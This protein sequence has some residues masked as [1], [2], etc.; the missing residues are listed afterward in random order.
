MS[1]PISGTIR[2]G[3]AP[4]RPAAAAPSAARPKRPPW[5]WLELIAVS[6]TIIPA[7][8]YVPG[9]AAIRTPLRMVDYSLVLLV[10]GMIL[11]FGKGRQIGRPFVPKYFLGAC[12][13][14]LLVSILHPTT[15]SLFSGLAQA[16]LVISIMCPV[17]WVPQLTISPARMGRLLRLI[18]L[19]NMLSSLWGLGQ[20]Y[21]P[22]RFNPPEIAL[23]KRKEELKGALSL[24]TSSG[25]EIIRPCGLTDIPGGASVASANVLFIGLIWSMGPMKLWRRAILL[26]LGFTA[27]GVIYLS[28]VRAILL[29]TVASLMVTA[30]VL[31]LRRDF[32]KAMILSVILGSLVVG[33]LSWAAFV[34]GEEATKRFAQLIE[35]DAM[36]TYQKNRG[37]FVQR[38]IEVDI[39]RF[40][41]GAGLGR[42]GQIFYYFG[43]K[44][45]PF[46][47]GRGEL[48]SEV[49]LTAWIYDGGLPLLF[50]YVAAIGIAMWTTLRIALRGN[51]PDV[52]YWACAVFAMGL[53]L[54]A[55]AMGAMPFIG[56]TGVQ[57]WLLV[58]TVYVANEQAGVAAR[59]AARAAALR[60]AT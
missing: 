31:A 18:F 17:F 22:D 43:N 20:V 2:G 6:P 9:A 7:L 53:A 30:A 58:T 3:M 34:G 46:G 28:Q 10:W 47:V 37:G 29:T 59:K 33:G 5:G 25:R 26:G 50:G 14:W 44:S 60:G 52:S 4:G 49:Q 57:F 27:M 41:L 23:F 45:D 8:Q 19:A 48:Y 16:M 36:S 42:W 35:E 40:P 38:T 51:D 39:P 32:V 54:I 13:A 56:P 24:K 11:I 1:I 21:Q 55:S 15:N 12:A